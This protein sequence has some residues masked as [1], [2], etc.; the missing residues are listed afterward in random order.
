MALGGLV[1]CVPCGP[2]AV[3]NERICCRELTVTER[4]PFKWVHQSVIDCK[5][6]TCGQHKRCPIDWWNAAGKDLLF[7]YVTAQALKHRMRFLYIRA[8]QLRSRRYV[9]STVTRGGL[10]TSEHVVL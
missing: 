5:K 6:R 4:L 3:T 8:L 10:F 9:C 7:L 1:C 2:H